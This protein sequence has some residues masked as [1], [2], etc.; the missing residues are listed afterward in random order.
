MVSSFF[1]LKHTEPL[2]PCG[3]TLSFVSNDVKLNS[4][5]QRTTLS[6][7]NDITFLHWESRTAMG[8]DIFVPLLETTILRNVV[9]VIPTN[10]NGALHFGGNNKP[11]DDLSTDRHISSKGAFLVNV[12]SLDCG[13]RSF[14]AETNVFHPTHG[15]HF[16]SIRCTFAC[17]EDGILGLVGLFVLC[18]VSHHP[19]IT[20]HVRTAS[21][22]KVRSRMSSLKCVKWI[23]LATWSSKDHRTWANTRFESQMTKLTIALFV[24]PC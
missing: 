12:S 4:L 11:L 7:C 8:M 10:D 18:I 19:T 20:W 16:F 15:F 9:K 6:N 3:F 17:D 14:D 2:S 24:F 22:R 21:T 23:C 13:V 1:V 5:R